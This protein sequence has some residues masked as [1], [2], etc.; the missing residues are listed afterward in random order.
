MELFVLA[1][2]VCART[3]GSTENATMTR[4]F[5]KCN[6]SHAYLKSMPIAALRKYNVANTSSAVDRVATQCL[7]QISQTEL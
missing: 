6:A 5:S 7:N 4:A 2:P 1:L 3:S